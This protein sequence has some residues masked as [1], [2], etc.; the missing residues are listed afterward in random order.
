MS[1]PSFKPMDD[2]IF[3]L[4]DA[5][6]HGFIGAKNPLG[7]A[8]ANRF[9]NNSQFIAQNRLAAHSKAWD[10]CLVDEDSTTTMSGSATPSGF[11]GHSGSVGGL[12]QNDAAT[13]GFEFSTHPA[14]PL[15]IPFGWRLSPGASQINVR[16]ALNVQNAEGAMYAYLVE[17][18]RAASPRIV[19]VDG[20]NDE[21]YEA[22][23]FFT[24]DIR[25]ESSYAALATTA[26]SG[27]SGLSYYDLEINIP[28]RYTGVENEVHSYDN[29]ATVFLCFQS[30]VQLA[31][32][33][34]PSLNAT[35]PAL[36][37]GNRMLTTNSNMSKYANIRNPGKN[38]NVIKLSYTD[39]DKTETWHQ[40]VQMRPADLSLAPFNASNPEQYII[41]PSVPTD[42]VPPSL[43]D[44]TNS[45]AAEGT[46]LLLGDQFNLYPVTQ[47]N[48]YSVS[49]Q[50]S[51]S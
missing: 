17:N 19:A 37:R 44:G 23:E 5:K 7:A 8:I 2:G 31:S 13:L 3:V 40:I 43:T 35:A 51:Y 48:V 25:A 42:V 15:A 28:G 6:W 21:T 18:N 30:G 46:G 34:T 38:H 11:L 29:N 26:T 49:I 24:S 9:I 22:T 33:S 16:V 20:R 47:F 12:A 39:T 4:P 50:E 36:E 41:W 14:M 27:T 32:G 1:I 45:F 10:C